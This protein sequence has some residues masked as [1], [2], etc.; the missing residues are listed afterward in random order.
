MRV[1][2]IDVKKIL[3]MAAVFWI[4]L[5]MVASAEQQKAEEYRQILQSGTFY[6]EYAD[7]VNTEAGQHQMLAANNG[8][9]IK[10]RNE[11]KRGGGG[12]LGMIVPFAG[13]IES[14]DRIPVTMYKDG[15]L[16]Q[17][18]DKKIGTVASLEQLKS[19][20]L[21][22]REN[23]QYAKNNI[24]LPEGLHVFALNDAYNQITSGS[25]AVPRY[26]GSSIEEIDKVAYEVDTYKAETASAAGGVLYSTNYMLYYAN[27]ELKIISVKL[28]IDEGEAVETKRYII[29]KISSELPDGIM[30][31]PSGCQVY[32]AGTGDMNDLIENPVLAETF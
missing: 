27:N 31:I 20:T 18:K 8:V 10:W 29:Y 21:N 23:W 17:F 6:I 32:I 11:I 12:L 30:T 7:V 15:K 3:M 24:S 28:N 19:E 26:I 22:P 14:K 16:Y 9:R 5:G 25:S 4:S 2:G 1:G 13:L